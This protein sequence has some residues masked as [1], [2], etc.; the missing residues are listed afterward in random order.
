MANFRHGT[1]ILNFADAVLRGIAQVML[2]N[3][4]YT[5]L[6]FLIGIFYHSFLFGIAVL[7]GTIVS[8]LT[9]VFLFADCSQTR[10]GL[11][12]FNGALVA[13]ALIYFLEPEALTWVYLIFASIST[14]I[15][16]AAVLRIFEKRKMPVLTAPFV[17]TALAF[18]LACARFGRLHST[19][20]LPTAGLPKAATVEGVVTLATVIEGVFMGI[21]QVFFQGSL[22]TGI[23]FSIG[24]FISS[25]RSCALAL[26]GSFTGLAV[27][28]VLGASE[29]SIRSGAF[30]FNTVLTVIA[31]GGIFLTPRFSSICY[32]LFAGVVTTIAFA[33]ISAAFEPIGMPALTLPFVLVTWI[34]VL[35]SERFP[36]IGGGIKM[37]A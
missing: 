34:F 27:A 35:A 9:A 30:G 26:L 37:G 23:L 7:V 28:W 21:A 17:F 2:Q 10:S 16:M 36:R 1:R 13:I 6:L 19:T 22:V 29:P 25:W 20:I 15:L 11:F 4:A 33:A 18:L 12:G 32:A 5:G 14:T 8:T 24:L 31:V 3:N